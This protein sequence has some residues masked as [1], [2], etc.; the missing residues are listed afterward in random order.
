MM[1]ATMWGA[2]HDAWR[3]A[4]L[5][6]WGV[7]AHGGTRCEWVEPTRKVRLECIADSNEHFRQRAWPHTLA[8]KS[9][10]TNVSKSPRATS[11]PCAESRNSQLL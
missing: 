3:S 7:R 11:R 9:L 4:L 6:R 5:Q 1:F 2:W 10:G 8:T